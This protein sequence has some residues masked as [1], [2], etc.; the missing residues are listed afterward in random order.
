[1]ILKYNEFNEYKLNYLDALKLEP[2]TILKCKSGDYVLVVN[3][4]FKMTKTGE[5]KTNILIGLTIC[6]SVITP[7]KG[8]RDFKLTGLTGLELI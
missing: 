5:S 2:G 3:E 6:P 4:S 1:M 8:Y 7:E